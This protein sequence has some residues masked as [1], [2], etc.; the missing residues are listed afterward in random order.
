[1]IYNEMKE[2]LCHKPRRWL[3]TGAA[4]FIG[5]HLVEHL[6]LLDQNVVGLDNFSN[7]KRGNLDQVQGRPS[8]LQI[9]GLAEHLVKEFIL[10]KGF[11]PGPMPF[12]AIHSSLIGQVQ[13]PHGLHRTQFP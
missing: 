10:V 2:S 7:G 3:V 4:G 13:K 11:L 12:N 1:M 5:S 6:L 8:Y 9:W